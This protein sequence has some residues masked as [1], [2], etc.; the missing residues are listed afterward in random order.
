MKTLDRMLK[1]LFGKLWQRL[2]L[3]AVLVGWNIWGAVTTDKWWLAVFMVLL[4]AGLVAIAIT[5]VIISASRGRP[6]SCG[7]IH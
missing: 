7:K 6:C 1:L 5:E 2:L 3:D 4:S